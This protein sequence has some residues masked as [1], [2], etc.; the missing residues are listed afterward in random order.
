[1]SLFAAPPIV[2]SDGSVD[3]TYEFKAQLP[4]KSG[5][6]GRFIE[7]ASTTAV[8]SHFDIKHIEGP[9][10]RRLVSF[11]CNKP[12][13]SATPVDKPITINL[14]VTHAKTADVT[15]VAEQLNQLKNML[16]VAGFITAF[17]KGQIS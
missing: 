9:V 4:E 8:D 1:M 14:T 15:H 16:S 2:L 11:R 7:P 10:N 12:D 17:L 6:A 3:H 5:I 13:T